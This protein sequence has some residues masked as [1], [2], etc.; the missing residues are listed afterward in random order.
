MQYRFRIEAENSKRQPE[1]NI[2]SYI[3]RLKTLVGKRW[4]TPPDADANARTACEKQRIGEYKD[5]FIPVVQHPLDLNRKHT[6]H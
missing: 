6:R 3:H 5:Y 1:E 4:P 2:K